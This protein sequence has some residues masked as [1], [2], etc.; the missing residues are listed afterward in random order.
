MYGVLR[1]AVVH[2]VGAYLYPHLLTERYDVARTDCVVVTSYTDTDLAI[3]DRLFPAD[4]CSD[5]V[6]D[7]CIVFRAYGPYDNAPPLIRLHSPLHFPS[8]VPLLPPI[9]LWWAQ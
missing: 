3:T 4:I 2:R 1:D 8:D 5:V 9:T 6:S 7:D